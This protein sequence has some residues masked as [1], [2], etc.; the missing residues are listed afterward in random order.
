M[1]LRNFS[2]RRMLLS[3]RRKKIHKRRVNYDQETKRTNL[4]ASSELPDSSDTEDIPAINPIQGAASKYWKRH[5]GG[6]DA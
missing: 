2:K 6:S 4:V 5:Y 1:C 3:N